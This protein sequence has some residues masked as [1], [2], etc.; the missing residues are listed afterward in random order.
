MD[1]PAPII[2]PA[3]TRDL[4]ALGRLGAELLRAH[5]EFDALRFIPP[6]ED[7][8]GGYA[9]F[10]GTRLEEEADVVLVAERDGRIIGYV[11]AGVEP[12]SWKELRDEAGFIHDLVVDPA[13]RGSGVGAALMEQGIEWLRRRG[14]A[15]VML[16]TAQRNQAAQRLFEG[17]GFRA[18]MIEMTMELTG[19]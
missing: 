11:Y 1:R 15:R 14:V 7:P 2:R 8:E 5:H 12:M 17:H 6:G 13:E 16:W 9:W 3:E 10:L 18:T 19:P 4:P